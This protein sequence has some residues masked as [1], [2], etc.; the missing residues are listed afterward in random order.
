MP[1]VDIPELCDSA[2]TAALLRVPQSTLVY[3][4]AQDAGPRWYKIGRRV[5]YDRA[6]LVAFLEQRKRLASAS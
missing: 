2:E 6:G 5:M 1:S 3:W 4:R